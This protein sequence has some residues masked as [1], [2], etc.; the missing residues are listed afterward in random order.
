MT[1]ARTLVAAVCVAAGIATSAF[2]LPVL[3]AQA[4]SGIVISELRVRGPNG[5]S[6][7]F[8]EVFNNST[9]AIDISGW[10]IKGS[11]SAGTLGVRVTIASN[12]ALKAGCYFLATNSSTS[13]GPYS[14]TVAGDQT[15]ATGITDDGGIAITKADDT[16]VDQ[17]G[18]S[19]G[20]AFKEGT[21]L[22]SLGSSNLNRGYE[23]RAGTTATYLDDGN[24]GAD[25]AVRSPSNPQ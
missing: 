20:S 4:P 6:D 12:T 16:I 11:N 10:K 14:G 1:R 3:R 24:N 21:F 18:L 7:E 5:G 13:G 8:V 23:R 15:Y 25:F 9:A 19:A 22:P 17:V 2:L